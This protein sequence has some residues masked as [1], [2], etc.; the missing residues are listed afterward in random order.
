MAISDKM[1]AVM[2]RDLAQSLE[3]FYPSETLAESADANGNPVI[4]FGSLTAGGAVF[5]V[6]GIDEGGVD[7]LGNTAR[8]YAPHVL[9]LCVEES[10]TT[11]VAVMTSVV[12]AEILALC[13][14]SGAQIEVYFSANGDAPATDEMV[15]ANLV[16]TIW[17]DIYNK[18]KQAQ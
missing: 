10:A 5:R 3:L 8:I 4:S 1:S 12:F 11:D 16:K 15:A 7:A 6:K 17:P 14:H 9:Q 18:V 13:T 2:A